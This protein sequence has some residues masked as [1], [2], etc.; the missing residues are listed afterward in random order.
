MPQPASIEYV[1]CSAAL[2]LQRLLQGLKMPGTR[3]IML[4]VPCSLTMVWLAATVGVITETN[5]EKAI[6]EL[7]AYEVSRTAHALMANACIKSCL[8]S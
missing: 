8:A 6:E 3:A 1:S 4:H 5:A 2:A 7:K